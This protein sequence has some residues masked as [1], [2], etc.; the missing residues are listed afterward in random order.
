MSNQP[1]KV[2]EARRTNAKVLLADIIDRLVIDLEY[3]LV[4]DRV[5]KL[6]G[7]QTM[8]EQSECSRVV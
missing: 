6:F 8:N 2:G 7:E 4:V 5:K 1:V 3:R